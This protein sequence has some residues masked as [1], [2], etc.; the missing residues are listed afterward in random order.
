MCICKVQIRFKIQ[1][2]VCIFKWMNQLTC[3]GFA[4]RLRKTLGQFLNAFMRRACVMYISSPV[5]S[6]HWFPLWP[7]TG[8]LNI[9]SA[10]LR[11]SWGCFSGPSKLLCHLLFSQGRCNI[12][13]TVGI[14]IFCTSDIVFQFKH[15]VC[16]VSNCVG[17]S[18]SYKQCS[19]LLPKV[20]SA[21]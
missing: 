9:C 8:S 11:S 12:F 7:T 5:Y 2:H 4:E 19:E 21:H 16:V 1:S 13:L 18:C 10:Q 14:I 3:C 20:K 6:V 17:G 15:S